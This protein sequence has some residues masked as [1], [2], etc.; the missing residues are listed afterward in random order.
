MKLF[1]KRQ[2][3]AAQLV[4]LSFLG[5]DPQE[6]QTVTALPALVVEE[7]PSKTK[8]VFATWGKK[9]SKKM[10]QLRRAD[11]KSRKQNPEETTSMNH[12]KKS[13]DTI[14]LDSVCGRVIPETWRSSTIYR[15]VSASRLCAPPTD[16][17]PKSPPTSTAEKLSEPCA[18]ADAD[19]TASSTH[20]MKTMSCDNLDA[21]GKIPANRKNAFPYAYL[22]CRLGT[23]P[24]EYLGGAGGA[25]TPVIT[26]GDKRLERLSSVNLSS[27]A[28]S[29]ESLTTVNDQVVPESEGNYVKLRNLGANRC[30]SHS[31]SLVLPVKDIGEEDGDVYACVTGVR[32][33]ESGYES[34]GTR[35][36]SESPLDTPKKNHECAEVCSSAS[37]KRRS[38][39]DSATIPTSGAPTHWFSPCPD[40]VS[41]LQQEEGNY[42]SL[43]R[44]PRRHL[45][46][47]QRTLSCSNLLGNSKTLGH[48]RI[49]VVQLVKDGS[50]ELG[51]YITSHVDTSIGLRGYVVAH[52]EKGGLAD[53]DGRLQV[54]DELVEVNGRKLRGVTLEEA[55]NA[56]RNTSRDVTLLVARKNTQ[57]T[58]D[59]LVENSQPKDLR[60]SSA[61]DFSTISG[62]GSQICNSGLCT[63][64]RRRKSSVF[65]INTI[66][67]EK[68]CGKKSLGF[69]VVGG[70]DS[71]KGHMGIYVKSIFPNG[72]AAETNLLKEGDEIFTVN[73]QTLEG[74]S[75]AEAISLFKRIK[76]GDVVLHIGRKVSNPRSPSISQSCCQLEIL[77]T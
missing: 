62:G 12:T 3:P 61:F 43:P 44:E 14:S 52:I 41:L 64:P 18:D 24:E 47:H 75:H 55:R 54:E 20:P 26:K 21:L 68:G 31:L 60:T 1:K 27:R 51:I 77:N 37:I 35:T 56:L 17:S 33:D 2:Q 8:K 40:R 32:S 63:L 46:Q 36:V 16:N 53:R 65:Q 29:E 57:V 7:M 11:G 4:K 6:Y 25:G 74:L 10:E 71:P 28:V 49:V 70:R 15:S 13:E 72:Q 73:G 50:G 23:V 59:E 9:M 58:E 66:V 67:F 38:S 30:R 76:Q 42:G 39:Y 45:R 5:H 48:T 19:P 22:R 69:S 34:D